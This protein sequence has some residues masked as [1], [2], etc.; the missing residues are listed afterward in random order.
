MEGIEITSPELNDGLAQFSQ[1]MQDHGLPSKDPSVHGLVWVGKIPYESLVSALKYWP[2]P[3]IPKELLH[4]LQR[5][6]DITYHFG[7]DPSNEST[8]CSMC[9][10]DLRIHWGGTEGFKNASMGST[11]PKFA[12][13]MHQ[14]RHDELVKPVLKHVAESAFHCIVDHREADKSS[15]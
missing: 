4:H 5:K 14:K 2:G 12:G 6:E 11:D 3:P 13:L 8:P 15:T 1:F 7:F 10:N 9:L